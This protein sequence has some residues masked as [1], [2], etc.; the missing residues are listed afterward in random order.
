MRSLSASTGSSSYTTR[1]TAKSTG[2]LDRAMETLFEEGTLSPT[3]S[4]A[5]SPATRPIAL[6]G[7]AQRDSVSKPPKLPMRSH[8]SPTMSTGRLD[9]SGH[10]KRPKV[11]V[12]VRCE[13]AIDDGRWIQMDG[14]SV[15]CDKCWKTMYLPKVSLC[16]AR[17]CGFF[18]ARRQLIIMIIIQCRRCNLTIEKQ[19]VSSSDGQLKG[20]YHRDCFN[21]HTCHVRL[22]FSLFRDN[23]LTMS[24][25]NPSPIRVSM[26]LTESRSA[27]T[28]IT[29]RTTLYVPLLHVASL[30][31]A[32]V[33]SRTPVIGTTPST[34]CASI[35]AAQNVCWSTTRW[36]GGCCASGTH[37]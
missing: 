8:T 11:K 12:C 33:P 37:R 28:I 23:F 22:F 18:S 25:R 17:S 4:N 5:Q 34:L 35:R 29:K 15:L 36:T 9:G 24:C 31:K 21:C 26:S 14:G 30:S 10:K 27:H 2:A 6:A 1:M 32:P 13:G 19:A 16:H 3:G 20:K 7:E